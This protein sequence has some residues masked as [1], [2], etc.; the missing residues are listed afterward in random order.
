MKRI[1]LGQSDLSVTRLAYGCMRYAGTWNPA[2]VDEARRQHAYD[3]IHTALDAGYNFFDH[4]DI[5]CRG[6]CEQIF[7]EVLVSQPS[8]RD[9]IVI[10]TKCGI[11]Q[12]G[13]PNPDSPH[14]YD[15]SKEHILW[16]CEQSLKKL[17]T[18]VIDLYQLH[19]P[20]A[21][22]NPE[23]IGEAFV[24]LHEQGKVRY[25]GVSNFCPS[26]VAALQSGLPFPIIVN[27][28]EVHLRRLAPF[29][30][31]TLDQC[32]EKK[33]VPLSWSPLGGGR[34]VRDSDTPE[35]REKAEKIMETLQQVADKYETSWSVIALSWL[36][37][38]P[39]GIL[40]IVGSSNPAHIQEMVLADEIELDREDWYRIFV[41]ARM[42]RLP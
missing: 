24:K 9:K 28:I 34:F 41:A 23:E 6:E 8:L 12:P 36:L 13:E 19:R 39:S 1:T 33:I 7:G 32:I 40:P 4:A 14:R 15:F 37:K 11:R 22:M 26:T 25:F 31:G 3:C 2:E 35:V 42:E 30:D 38:H 16:S 5:Y 17:Q 27:Q 29:Y 21:L 18:D 20:D 10:A